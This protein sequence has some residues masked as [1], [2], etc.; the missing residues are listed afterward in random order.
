MIEIN[1]DSV[2]SRLYNC[3][4]ESAYNF[5][6]QI[7]GIRKN[8]MKELKKASIDLGN[9]GWGGKLIDKTSEHLIELMKKEK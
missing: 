1:I 5:A 7:K 2:I 6:I 4:F 8:T 9:C 3:K